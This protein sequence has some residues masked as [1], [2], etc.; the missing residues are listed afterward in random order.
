MTT[1]MFEQPV[2]GMLM[3]ALDRYGTRRVGF[4]GAR[5]AAPRGLRIPCRM[6]IC[7]L[8]E[9]GGRS[10]TRTERQLLSQAVRWYI[11]QRPE[12]YPVLEAFV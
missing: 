10:L 1:P 3:K 6:L 8:A 5:R 2:L 7:S 4:I 11:R 9:E 12:L